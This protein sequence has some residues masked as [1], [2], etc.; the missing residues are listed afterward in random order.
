[1]TDP[2]QDPSGQEIR[3]CPELRDRI[4]EHMPP[5]AKSALHGVAVTFFPQIHGEMELTL[6]YNPTDNLLEV[7]SRE[8][9][10]GPN[11]EFTGRIVKNCE[12]RSTTGEIST[13]TEHMEP[14]GA[15]SGGARLGMRLAV[16]ENDATKFDTPKLNFFMSLFE[17][18]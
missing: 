15:E 16:A 4:F 11:D 13:Y 9:V 10:Y 6:R 8:G 2:N 1:M 14:E 18:I 12:L 3:A 17:S 7:E 5:Q